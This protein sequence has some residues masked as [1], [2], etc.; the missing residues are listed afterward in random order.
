MRE[1]SLKRQKFP[2]NLFS[3]EYYLF[4]NMSKPGIKQVV[5]LEVTVIPPLKSSMQKTRK[6]Y[7]KISR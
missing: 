1:K 7:P 4:N 6:P 3:A 5:D 2:S